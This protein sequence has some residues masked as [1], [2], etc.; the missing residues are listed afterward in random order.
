MAKKATNKKAPKY[1]TQFEEDLIWMSYRYA[2][3]R[4]T[5]HADTHAKNLIQYLPGKLSEERAQ[6][7]ATDIMRSIEDSLRF[8]NPS[9]YTY[10]SENEDLLGYADP[11]RI[12]K[13]FADEHD[14]KT[15]E[16]LGSY[17]SVTKEYDRK[18]VAKRHS[19]NKKKYPNY[20][21]GIRDLLIWY[22]LAQLL[23][24][25]NHRMVTVENGDLKETVECIKVYDMDHGTMKL[26]EY[27]LPIDKFVANPWIKTYCDPDF[28]TKIE[29]V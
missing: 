25:P 3:G 5:I 20:G 10:Y 26:T 28:I 1:L 14:I 27:W 15:P 29:E 12:Y 8:G 19:D 18:W 22:A 16:E 9:I 17:S 21:E 13:E 2:I 4:H 23:Y 6:F 7:M 24:K 11:I